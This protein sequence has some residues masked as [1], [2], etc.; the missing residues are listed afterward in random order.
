MMLEIEVRSSG[1]G[2]IRGGGP[3][4]LAR[5]TWPGVALPLFHALTMWDSIREIMA[6][7]REGVAILIR[8]AP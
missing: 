2:L 4:V 6:T 8:R 1:P 3:E 5:C 7:R